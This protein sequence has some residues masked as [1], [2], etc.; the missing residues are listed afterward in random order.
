MPTLSLLDE[1]LEAWG[2]ARRGVIAELRSVPPG[3]IDFRPEPGARSVA[4]IAQH[5]VDTAL[6]WCV[7]L[8]NPDGDFTR[9]SFAE[10][11]EAHGTPA[12]KRPDDRSGLVRLLRSTHAAGA[13]RLR[14]VGDVGILQTIR[15]FDGETGT[16]LA[17]LH[18]G[19]A[20][21]E[22]HRGQLALYVRLLG[23]TP[24]LTRLIA[25]A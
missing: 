23:R 25:G 11:M 8:S 19:I 2:D 22:Y 6:M 13:R 20:N 1:A 7:E 9:M 12:A 24:A 17:W 14:R 16:R 5:V 3:Q 18:H 10:F 15:R 21:E 4:E